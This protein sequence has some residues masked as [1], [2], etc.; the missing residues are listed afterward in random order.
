MCDHFRS[1]HDGGRPHK[2]KTP[3]VE[4]LLK[5]IQHLAP[6]KENLIKGIPLAAVQP[7]SVLDNL[8]CSLCC[9]ILHRPIQ[10]PCQTVV[11]ADCL[12]QYL[13]KNGCLQ[14]PCKGCCTTLT[15]EGVK[16]APSIY[17]NLL[18][19][20]ALHCSSCNVDIRAGLYQSH[21]CNANSPTSLEPLPLLA[22][23]VSVV[24]S[25]ISCSTPINC[26]QGQGQVSP[27]IIIHRMLSSSPEPDVITVPTGGRV[28][29]RHDKYY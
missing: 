20:V 5:H 3:L 18:D 7:I 11:C 19:D 9:D 28:C 14:C 17:M 8:K 16:S 15:A 29:K 4:L 13:V 26:E 27:A 22:P 2:A 25:S 1:Q 6:N 12:A 23:R 21:K 24:Q 10:L